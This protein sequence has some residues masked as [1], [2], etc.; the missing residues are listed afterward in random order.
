MH[1]YDAHPAAELFPLLDAEGL[2]ALTADIKAHGLREPIVLHEGRV[3]DGRNR[4]RACEAAGVAPRFVQWS[5]EGSPWDFTW[6]TN[7]ERRH[8]EAGHKAVL[9]LKALAAT[10]E[11]TSEQEAARAR[12]LANIRRRPE[13][14]PVPPRQEASFSQ[15]APPAPDADPAYRVGRE[16]GAAGRPF[17]WSGNGDP[18]D[19]MLA[20]YTR[21]HADGARAAQPATA[22]AAPSPAAPLAAPTSQPRPPAPP[23]PPPSTRPAPKTR[24]HLATAAGVSPRVA[25][26][27]MTVQKH[28][29]EAFERVAR[30]EVSLKQAVRDVRQQARVDDAKKAADAAPA[31]PDVVIRHASVED[32]LR[33]VADVGLVHADP[34]WLY[35]NNSGRG[36]FKAAESHYDCS[37]IA[38]IVAA[39]DRAYDVALP[40][41]YLLLWITW[42]VL[43]EW[44]DAAREAG[45]RWEYASGGAWHKEG[46]PGIGFHW[47]GNSEPLLL[48]RKGHP[49][50]WTSEAT[51]NAWS[52]P[53]REGGHSEKPVAWLQQLVRH[54]SKPGALVLDLYAGM[55]PLARACA[56]ERRRY[57]GAEIDADRHKMALGRL[58]A[59]GAP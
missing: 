18:D 59:S 58:G 15:V 28:S 27:A 36:G 54:F 26:D 42:P 50:P 44:F 6:S 48:Y 51:R 37:R 9:K 45:L 52:S 3:L 32:V 35:Q 43:L 14:A 7:A 11:W 1:T 24:D 30:G 34:P 10:E 17:N 38:D 16:D 31:T 23:P 12:S 39:L 55:A 13:V 49:K 33:D 41:T 19:E 46:G 8:L 56:A 29:T 22:P 40:D 53:G 20:A 5:G 47:R 21:G 25:Q 2:T 57:V 4:L